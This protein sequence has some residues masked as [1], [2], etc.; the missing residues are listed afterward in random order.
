MQTWLAACWH[1]TQ[2]K[3][4]ISATTLAQMYEMTYNTAW[5]LLHK[6]RWA[7]DQTGKEQ[8]RGEIEIDETWLGAREV[9]KGKSFEKKHLVIVA[10]EV[11]NGGA[12]I[13]RA[14]LQRAHS[15]GTVALEAFIEEHIEPGSILFSDGNEAYVNAVNNLAARGLVYKLDQTVIKGNPAPTA[16]L[17]LHVHR[18]I[19]LAK[20]WLLGTYQGAAMGQHLD[21]YLDEYTFR[22]NRRHSRN[23]GLLFY[24]LVCSLT[25]PGEAVRYADL[26]DRKTQLATARKR[27]QTLVDAEKKRQQSAKNKRAYNRARAIERG[28]EPAGPRQLNPDSVHVAPVEPF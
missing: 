18:V 22:F 2:S 24:R 11:L 9:V 16:S 27:H 21:S 25:A 23:R 6:I 5:V 1:M 10:C 12:A 3:P 20:R 17:L 15:K 13:G 28:E 19:S 26:R 8:L 7:M 14:R 4:G